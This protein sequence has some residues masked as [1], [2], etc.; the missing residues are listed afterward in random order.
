MDRKILF[1]CMSSERGVLEENLPFFVAADTQRKRV[2]VVNNTLLSLQKVSPKA[3][4]WTTETVREWFSKNSVEDINTVLTTLHTDE[5]LSTEYNTDDTDRTSTR[6][7]NKSEQ[8][9][10]Q[11]E[12]ASRDSTPPSEDD[13]KEIEPNN[14]NNARSVMSEND[15]RYP[16][17]KTWKIFSCRKLGV[18]LSLKDR[19]QNAASGRISLNW[20]SVSGQVSWRHDDTHNTFKGKLTLTKRR[21]SPEWTEFLMYGKLGQKLMLQLGYSTKQNFK[22]E[23]RRILPSQVQEINDKM[24]GM[25]RKDI[26]KFGRDEFNSKDKWKQLKVCEDDIEAK[27]HFY[28]CRG[29]IH[30][31][32]VFARRLDPIVEAC[33]WHPTSAPETLLALQMIQMHLEANKNDQ[34]APVRRL[35]TSFTPQ[36]PSNIRVRP[37]AP[38]PM[39]QARE[40]P[41]ETPNDSDPRDAINTHK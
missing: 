21:D 37:L 31:I 30:G 33:F 39:I 8:R 22:C 4:K 19:W 11:Q 27:F 15:L 24:K 18:D 25:R 36:G 10:K 12:K 28:T 16:S 29:R 32:R 5:E 1:I 23:I 6:R 40:S 38:K 14:S 17:N 35:D 2:D 7:M 9:Q 41:Q 13:Q 34:E 3:K 26:E 20:C